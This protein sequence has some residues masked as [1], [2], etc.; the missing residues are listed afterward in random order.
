MRQLFLDDIRDPSWVYGIG[1]DSQW[2]VV[3]SYAQFI[4]WLATYG[5]PARVSFDHDLGGVDE[6]GDEVD[7]STVPTGMDCAHALVDYCLDH[8][9]PLPDF[10]VHSANGPGAAN[11]RGLLTSFLRHQAQETR[12]PVNSTPSTRTP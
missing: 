5:L 2:E 12:S 10:E 4:Q 7:P 9:L 6:E 1:A 8:Q 3:R 11:I